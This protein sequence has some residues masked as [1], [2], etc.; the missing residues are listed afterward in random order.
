MMSKLILQEQTRIITENQ[1]FEELVYGYEVSINGKHIV[2]INEQKYL[3]GDTKTQTVTAYNAVIQAK[4]NIVFSDA[5]MS[6][7]NQM[8][9]D[10]K[11]VTITYFK[12]NL[13]DNGN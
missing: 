10:G 13:N 4:F 5:L 9:F 8:L 6:T 11:R 12:A 2:T 7:E 3:P 1:V